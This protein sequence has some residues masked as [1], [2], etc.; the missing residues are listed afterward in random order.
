MLLVT[1]RD[2]QHRARRVL[3]VTALVGLVLTL[4]FLMTGLV[5]QLN[6]ESG[7][8]VDEIGAEYWVVA[9][10]VSGPFT[11][12]SVLA[13]TPP[14]EA[15]APLVVAR[16]TLLL[17]DGDTEIVVIGHERGELGAPRVVEG[18]AA[19]ADSEVVVD[20]SLDL[21]IGT[22]VG[23]GGE[24]YDIVG[25]SRDTTVLAG[26]PFVF[27][28]LERAQQLAFTSDAVVSAY[29]ADEDPG[30]L[31]GAVVLTA[32]EVG[33]D[34][35]G[36]LESAISSIDLIRVLLW[37]VAAIVIGAV[38]FL[39]AL[40]R[41]RDFA[42]MKAV[43]AS[44]R[45]VGLGLALQAVLMALLGA[46]VAAVLATVVEPVFPLAVRVPDA[47]YVQVPVGAAVVGLLVAL[48]GVRRVGRIDPADAFAGAGR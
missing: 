38:V 25:L 10:G 14:T 46:A 9:E 16:G 43:G 4:L 27:M 39:S 19:E 21:A 3:V 2:L 8:A 41:Q 32:T 5:N 6:T 33:E 42:V 44:T 17:D 22:E 18:R 15:L 1:L 11:S 40:E 24:R 47:A 7:R 34:A 29:L 13:A 20:E 37:T 30:A 45:S 31:D 35:L 12:A 26:L 28:G 36:P 48:V 23:I